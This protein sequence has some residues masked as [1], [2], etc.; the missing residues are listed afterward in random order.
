MAVKKSLRTRLRYIE[1]Q[2]LS[3]QPVSEGVEDRLRVHLQKSLGMHN[4]PKLKLLSFDKECKGLLRC[5]AGS[6]VAVRQA[7]LFLY[8]KDY[9]IKLLKSS[10]TIKS[11]SDE[12]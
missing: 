10:G 6:F 2:L 9:R 7:L 12:E 3:A 1:F 4:A 8:D 5:D 11:L